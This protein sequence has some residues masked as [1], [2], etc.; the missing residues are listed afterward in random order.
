ME[1]HMRLDF[2]S[3]EGVQQRFPVGFPW[4]RHC[5]WGSTAGIGRWER[6][7]DGF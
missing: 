3:C 5:C 7:G 1:V 2:G 4:S 6:D